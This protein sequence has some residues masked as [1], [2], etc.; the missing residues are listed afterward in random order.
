MDHVDD[1]RDAGRRGTEAKGRFPRE[2]RMTLRT[3]GRWIRTCGVASV[4]VM[5]AAV[6]GALRGQQVD[7]ATPRAPHQIAPY[8]RQ[9]GPLQ[10]DSTASVKD[11][12]RMLLL[13]EET[14]FQDSTTYTAN[15]GAPALGFWGLR[16]GNRL[17]AIEANER[18]WSARIRGPG[19]V[20]AIFVGNMGDMTPL[21]PANVEGVPA[22]H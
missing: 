22:C 5:A 15:I 8:A 19:G 3:R 17:V 20:C 11:D 14:F 12:L 16:P 13:A 9:A 21:A 1:N 10:S 4:L 7:T 2:V 18:G 6:P